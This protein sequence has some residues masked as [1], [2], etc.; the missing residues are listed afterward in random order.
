M[1]DFIEITDSEFEEQVLNSD[2]PVLIDVWAPWCGPCRAIAP[3]IEQI[4]TEYKGRIK[5]GKLNV[6]DNAETARKYGVA[7]IP[8]L[9]I[10]KDGKPVKGIIGAIPKEQIEDMLQPFL[11][12]A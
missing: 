7:S 12:E 11:V 1:Q 10:F 4:A 5:V 6:D 8:A 2:L 3:A 9:M